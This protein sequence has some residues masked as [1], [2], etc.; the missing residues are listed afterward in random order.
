MLHISDRTILIGVF[1]L[2]L[3]PAP[4]RAG[5]ARQITWCELSAV[6]GKNVSLVMPGG[7]V[8][9]GKVAGVD[10]DARV[11]VTRTSDPAAYPKGEVRGR[12]KTPAPRKIR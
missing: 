12:S 8:I 1:L 2:L 4:V 10:A 7:A 3:T 5:S 6:I 9:G 11:N